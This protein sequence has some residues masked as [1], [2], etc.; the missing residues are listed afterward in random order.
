MNNCNEQS[1]TLSI[2]SIKMENKDQIQ[3]L[4]RTAKAMVADHKGLVAIDESVSTLNK[5]FEAAGIPQTEAFRR[6]YREV[7]ITTPGISDYI[8]GAILFDETV[9]QE[10]L[11]GIPFIQVLNEAGIIPGIKLD[12]GT[13]DLPGFS[14]EKVTKGLDDLAERLTAY[15][16]LGLRFA[17]WRGVILIDGLLPSEACIVSNAHALARYAAACQLAGIVPIVEPEVIMDGDHTIERCAEV[18]EK[19]L[20]E[21]FKQLYL[22]KVELGGL[23]LKPNMVLP[24]KDS[25]EKADADQVAALTVRCLRNA[26]PATVSGIAFLSGGQDP[27]E[28]SRNL[29]AINLH[30]KEELPWPVTYSFSRALHQPA[31][32]IWG[33][34]E[35][36]VKAAQ[37]SFI[38]Q[39][40]A[41]KAA[42]KGE[43]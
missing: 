13:E 9:Y 30:Y 29:N 6:A 16:K 31:L 10:T 14:G 33:G 27:L 39:A 20:R 3:E 8:N 19:V 24:G 35:E 12:E 41:N 21:L 37:E 4:I 36:N 23:I 17:K 34:K 32:E 43:L 11:S 5:R 1:V 2:I 42:R 18:T 26:V 7:L 38:Q 15:K 25:P 22:L 40:K 28:A